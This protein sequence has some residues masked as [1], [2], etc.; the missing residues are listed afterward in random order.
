MAHKTVQKYPEK[1][2]A[3]I[4]VERLQAVGIA[5]TIIFTPRE[6]A[7]VVTGIGRGEY[8]VNV[9]DADFEQACQL[10]SDFERKEKL[11]VVEDTSSTDLAHTE[12]I[13]PDSFRRM[14]S[15]ALLS[16]ILPVIFHV[17]AT[18]TYMKLINQ[19][20]SMIKKTIATIFLMACW[21]LLY[22][23]ISYMFFHT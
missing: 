22:F 18:I 21:S 11:S 3:N 8:S 9:D 2:Q 13:E 19:N 7:S 20:V 16:V 17:A 1:W 23:Q 10:E 15:C 6:Y 4:L 5:A 12:K 14:M